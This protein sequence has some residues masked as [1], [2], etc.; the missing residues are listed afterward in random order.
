SDGKRKRARDD[1]GDGVAEAG[2]NGGS[3]GAASQ[4]ADSLSSYSLMGVAD[5]NDGKD[6][7]GGASKVDAEAAVADGATPSSAVGDAGAGADASAAGDDDEVVEIPPPSA[8]QA[9]IEVSEEADCGSG[10]FNSAAPGTAAEPISIESGEAPQK[11]R[12]SKKKQKAAAKDLEAQH[13]DGGGGS[14]SAGSGE[15][16]P[17][18]K[19]RKS[20]SAK[21]KGSDGGSEGGSDDDG[22]KGNGSDGDGGDSGEGDGLEGPIL[23][24]VGQP[25]SKDM[26]KMAKGRLSKWA[27]KFTGTRTYAPPAVPVIEP[28]NDDYLASFGRSYAEAKS[29]TAQDKK[30]KAATQ[31]NDDDDDDDDD[32]QAGDENDSGG[33]SSS[34]DEKGPSDNKA[35]GAGNADAAEGAAAKDEG[36]ASPTKKNSRSGRRKKHG[37]FVVNLLYMLCD[38]KKLETL[39]SA[40]GQVTAVVLTRPPEGKT[41]SGSASVYFATAEGAQK[42]LDADGMAIRGRPVGIREARLNVDKRYFVEPEQAAKVP[43]TA[44]NPLAEAICTLCGAIGH[45]D[46]NCPF[47]ACSRCWEEGHLADACPYVDVMQE[48][49]GSYCSVCGKAGHSIDACK[50]APNGKSQLKFSCM[51]CRDDGHTQCGRETNLVFGNERGVAMT[52]CNC[53]LASHDRRFCPHQTEAEILREC[54]YRFNRCVSG[55][56]RRKSTG[57][58][59]RNH[60]VCYNCGKKGHGKSECPLQRQ[61]QTPG[62]FG[63]SN[64]YNRNDQPRVPAADWKQEWSASNNNTRSVNSQSQ[65]HGSGKS[66]NDRMG[67]GQ[68]HQHQPK[69]PT[70][71]PSAYLNEHAHPPSPLQPTRRDG[72]AAAFSG[73]PSPPYHHRN[74]NSHDNGGGYHQHQQERDGTHNRYQDQMA[75]PTDSPSSFPRWSD[76]AAVGNGGSGGGARNRAYHPGGNF[77][78][79]SSGGGGRRVEDRHRSSGHRGERYSSSRG[80]GDGYSG[81]G[82]DRYSGGGGDRYSGGRSS[83]GRKGGYPSYPTPSHSYSHHSGGSHQRSPYNGGQPYSAGGQSYSA[84]RQPYSAGGQSY[85]TGRRGGGGR[86]SHANPR[87]YGY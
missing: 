45:E 29:L 48:A 70:H 34:G 73:P 46:K 6:A 38:E 28:I 2:A 74:H 77:G 57:G 21:A 12:K 44:K 10:G 13:E 42:A 9:V 15:Q 20:A 83:G 7:A 31:G 78:S 26:T 84:G 53:G 33:D 5:E 60:M 67:S 25:M 17:S 22:S 58:G 23:F 16:R 69:Q 52:C 65:N 63:T 68:Q 87:S 37:V 18:K 39:F 43:N 64:N 71:L 3:G 27:L 35:N 61:T 41:V 30:E 19:A 32:G 75:T 51:T 79:D 8:A 56:H 81:G 40:F 62:R 59:G 55:G 4:G 86:D 47:N 80:G 85:S 66:R 24:T 50:T 76:N 49:P 1:D 54:G 14:G 36:S 72:G 11:K 82:G